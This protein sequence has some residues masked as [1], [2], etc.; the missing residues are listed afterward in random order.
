ME[1]KSLLAIAAVVVLL[2]GVG[3]AF[4]A[5]NAQTE[6]ADPDV[7]KEQAKEIAAD[8]VGGTAQKA[9]L[10]QENGPVWEVTVTQESGP[11]KEVEVNGTS[12]EVLEVENQDEDDGFEIG[13]FFE[14]D[15]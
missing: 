3:V 10:E 14:S 7:S 9:T 8:H 2:G 4:A 6:T 15:G 11:T 1:R 12:G 5:T 13:E